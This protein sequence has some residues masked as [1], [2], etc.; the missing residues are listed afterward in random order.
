MLRPPIGAALLVVAV[1]SAGCGESKDQVERPVSLEPSAEEARRARAAARERQRLREPA[2]RRE[3]ARRRPGVEVPR[4]AR[5]FI[6]FPE[7]RKRE[8]AAY[9]RRHYGIDSYRLEQPRAIVQHWTSLP[10]AQAAI[11]LF[12][13]DVPDP[14]LHELPATCAHF[15]ID[16]DG[17][18]RQLVPLSIMCRHTVGLN[19]TSIGIEHV[20]YSD[21][22][23]LSNEP[24][25]RASLRLTRWLRCRFGI[26]VENVIGHNE[27]RSSP[28]HRER[29]AR[30][31]TQTHDDFTQAT[32]DGYRSR[33][34]ERGC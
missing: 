11:D 21:Q 10:S 32:M 34:G 20:G 31:R 6:P 17:T 8:M 13:R 5:S 12:S 28:L 26:D 4:I 14:E 9:A 3:R 30:L 16:R 15:L 18:I 7:K 29:V 23:V 2:P 19:H 27:N 33:L 24:Q 25:L 22:E 1:L